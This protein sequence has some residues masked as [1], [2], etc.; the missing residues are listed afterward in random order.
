MDS[1]HLYHYLTCNLFFLCVCVC[2]CVYSVMQHTHLRSSVT[3][4]YVQYQPTNFNDLQLYLKC[5]LQLNTF[6]GYLPLCITYIHI[7]IP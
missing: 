5:T 2:V 7:Y 4:T 6:Y 3:A 1:F